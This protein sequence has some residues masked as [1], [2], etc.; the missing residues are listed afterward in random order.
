MKKLTTCR[1]SAYRDVDQGG[2]GDITPLVNKLET[3]VKEG[4]ADSGEW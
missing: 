2:S 3:F 4:K 1:C